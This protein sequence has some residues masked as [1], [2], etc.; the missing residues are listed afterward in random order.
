MANFILLF[1]TCLISLQSSL[2]INKNYASYNQ[3]DSILHI[4][5]SLR[6]KWLVSNV[7]IHEQKKRVLIYTGEKI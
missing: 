1:I 3:R 5:D 6:V 7:E 4:L 2:G